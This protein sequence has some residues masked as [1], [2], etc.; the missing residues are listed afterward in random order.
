MEEL[1]GPRAAH[2]RFKWYV[3]GEALLDGP[4]FAAK[5]G[6]PDGADRLRELW[7]AASL[8]LPVPERFPPDGLALEVHGDPAAP[9][10]FVI[11][12]PPRARNEASSIALIPGT[13]TP[14]RY[15]AFALERAVSLRAD[16]PVVFVVETDRNRRRSFGPP[17]EAGAGAASRAAFVAAILE[18]C[19]GKREPLGVTG[20]ELV[21]PAPDLARLR[22]SRN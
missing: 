4:G 7:D 13:G 22:A 1:E 18:I 15:R 14:V 8:D 11:P 6:A 3:I 19:D 10:V 5:Y 21:D 12:P 9:I 17:N 20:I 2:Q 16:E